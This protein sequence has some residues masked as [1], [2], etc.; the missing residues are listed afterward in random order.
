MMRPRSRPASRSAVSV[1]RSRRDLDKTF[2]IVIGNPPWTRL[3]DRTEEGE[4]EADKKE[5]K[6]AIAALNTEFTA[7]GRRVL[8]A[9]G[10]D[11]LA[12]DYHNPDNNPDLPF[13]WR[14]MEWAKDGGVIALAMPAR[15]FGRTPARALKHGAQSCEASR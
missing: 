1:P 3:R 13:L 7:I 12:K 14:A 15:L 10:L 6:S 2:D 4:D 11:E 9:R 8:E 5:R